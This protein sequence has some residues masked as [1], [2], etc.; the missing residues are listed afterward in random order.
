MSTPAVLE[1]FGV[2]L[3]VTLRLCRED[4]LAALEWF[5]LFTE[6]RELIRGA[7]ERQLQ[8]ENIML[9]A[10]VNGFPAGQT[11]VDLARFAARGTGLLWAVRVFPILRNR[12]IGRRLITAAERLLRQRGFGAAEMG[13]EKHNRDALRLYER[14]G[15]R[16]MREALDEYSYTT[17]DGV[18]MRITEE[19]LM[20]R[21]ELSEIP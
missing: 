21:K 15:Y 2:P 18:W 10:D 14:L 20:L 9:V 8:G 11:W 1:R 17:P 16:R 6:H 12:G 5:G 13:V 4:D 3:E 7:Y 19:L